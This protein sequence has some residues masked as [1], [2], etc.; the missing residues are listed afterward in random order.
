MDLS[1]GMNVRIV[2]G[3]EFHVN[4]VITGGGL[5]H[6]NGAAKLCFAPHLT[7]DASS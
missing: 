4:D 7:P 3:L 1:Y 6:L 2:T 5:D